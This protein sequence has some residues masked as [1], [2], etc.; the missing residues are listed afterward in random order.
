M[1][2]LGLVRHMADVERTGSAG[3]WPARRSAACYWSDAS[4][5]GDFDD[6]D[7]AE[8]EADFAVYAA[9]VEAARKVQA[10]HDYDDT[11]DAAPHA[12]GPR[13]PSTSGPSSCT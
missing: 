3:G 2:L 9:E 11:F 5:D 13:R 8:A 10:S 1:S 4:P 12:T 6:L 7:P